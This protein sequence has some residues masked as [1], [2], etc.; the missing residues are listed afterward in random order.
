[1]DFFKLTQN[2]IKSVTETA[3]KAGEAV[4]SAACVATQAVT[5]TAVMAGGG[6]G[7][8]AAYTG[9]VVVRTAVGVGEGSVSV[10]SQATKVVTGTA[11]V[12]GGAIG[13]AALQVT[14]R[15]GH[16]IDFFQKNPRFKE[17]T[18]KLQVDWLIGLID[19]VDAV[20]AETEV[21]RLQQQYPHKASSEIAHDLMVDK[22]LIAGSSGFTTSLVPGA[23]AVLFAVDFAASSVLQAE[24][25]LIN[26]TGL[27]Y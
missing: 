15:V 19:T 6:I 17:I 11:V 9:Q 10:A 13:G 23:A 26:I 21:K 8:A 24:M 7:N 5:E 2:A 12:A 18:E 20:K 14:G 1:M 3:T 16:A 22:A 4:G 25:A 27:L